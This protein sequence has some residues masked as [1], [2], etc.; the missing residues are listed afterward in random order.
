MNARYLALAALAG[1]AFASAAPAGCYGYG[2]TRTCIDPG[3]GST[4]TTTRFGSQSYTNGYNPRTGNSWNSNTSRF[5]NSSYTNGRDGDGN[6]WSLS[7]HRLGGTTVING[8]DSNGNSI[9]GTSTRIGNTRTTTIY[10]SD[11]TTVT[12]SCNQYGCF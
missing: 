8:Y 2:A 10:R 12:R 1:L 9:N 5:G 3:T 4:Y 7:T 11:G 6:G